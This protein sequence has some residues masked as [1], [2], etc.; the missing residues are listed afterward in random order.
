MDST[1]YR[2]T[3]ISKEDE[4][5]EFNL[6][7]SSLNKLITEVRNSPVFSNDSNLL[8]ETIKEL[9]KNNLGGAITFEVDFGDDKRIDYTTYQVIIKSDDNDE[10]INEKFKNSR[11]GSDAG[12]NIPRKV[13]FPLHVQLIDNSNSQKQIYKFTI[14]KI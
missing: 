13:S 9:K 7:Y 1:N 5:L 8:E 4:A 11:Y 2:V 12:I 14:E 6:S 3:A 10:I